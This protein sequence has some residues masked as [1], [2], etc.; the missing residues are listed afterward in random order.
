VC[1]KTRVRETYDELLG[2]A[3]GTLNRGVLK[4]EHGVVLLYIPIISGQALLFQQSWVVV[5]PYVKG[6]EG[7]AVLIESLVVELSELL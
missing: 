6:A 7:G 1:S 4:G 2:D 3:S 5:F